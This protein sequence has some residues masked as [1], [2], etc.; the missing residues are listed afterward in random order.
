MDWSDLEQLQRDLEVNRPELWAGED[1]RVAYL[2]GVLDTI[3]ELRGRGH[4]EV[5]L[6]EHLASRSAR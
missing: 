3:E 5:D 6:R 2:A 1:G 4:V